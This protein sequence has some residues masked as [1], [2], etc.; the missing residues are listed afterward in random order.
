MDAVLTHSAGLC[1]PNS[2]YQQTQSLCQ[3][4]LLVDTKLI[5]F[6]VLAVDVTD[7]IVMSSH[8]SSLFARMV[9]QSQCLLC[10]PLS[11]PKTSVLDF[12]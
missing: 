12:M 6:A 10:C 1:Q 2:W 11:S 8:A 9:F 4:A 3:P 5:E 7:L